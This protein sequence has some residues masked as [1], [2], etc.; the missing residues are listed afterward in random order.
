MDHKG[1]Y[2]AVTKLVAPL[3]VFGMVAV[4]GCGDADEADVDTAPVAEPAAPAGPPATEVQALQ[5]QTGAA[6]LAGQTVRVNGLMVVSLL[7]QH[8]FFVELPNKNPFLVATDGSVPVTA[9]QTVDVVGQVVVMTPVIVDEWVA[10]GKISE[11]DRPMA[12][13][14]SEFL[15]ADLVIPVAAAP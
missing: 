4:V 12:E 13:F 3:V 7:G 5:L 8:G 10:S 6:G 1:W 2:H 14:A 11:G 15:Q 9:R